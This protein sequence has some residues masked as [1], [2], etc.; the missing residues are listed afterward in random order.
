MGSCTSS[1]LCDCREHQT[2][3]H[4]VDSCPLTKLD[5]GLLSLHEADEDAISWLKMTATKALT[6]WNEWINIKWMFA[7][8]WTSFEWSL[9]L[10][11]RG[12]DSQLWPVWATNFS[13]WC[14]CVGH[15]FIQTVHYCKRTNKPISLE[16]NRIADEV[17]KH[18]A[19]GIRCEQGI[20]SL[21]SSTGDSR[22]LRQ[23]TE[24]K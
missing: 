22:F 24:L 1:P 10:N 4:T 16:V 9:K 15:D 3:E 5:G 11:A 7:H 21:H 18:H 13:R 12:Q 2:M 14:R 20:V 6:K 17:K 8:V 23:T 19:C